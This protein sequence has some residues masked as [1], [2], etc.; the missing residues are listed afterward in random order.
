M[1]SILVGPKFLQTFYS[2]W[3]FLSFWQFP[4]EAELL[5]KW[6][7]QCGRSGLSSFCWPGQHRRMNE[8]EASPEAS[9]EEEVAALERAILKQIE[10]EK[11]VG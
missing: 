4:G 1:K 9:P 7:A 3:V 2:S 8:P 11:E 10:G 6:R 5:R